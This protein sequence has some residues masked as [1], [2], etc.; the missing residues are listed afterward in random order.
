MWSDQPKSAR[1]PHCYDVLTHDLM[2]LSIHL[3]YFN[4]YRNAFWVVQVPLTESLVCFV[5][6][7]GDPP[8]HPWSGMT[9]SMQEEHQRTA[10]GKPGCCGCAPRRWG[11]FCWGSG[12]TP[13]C[14]MSTP[15]YSSSVHWGRQALAEVLKEAASNRRPPETDLPA[16][17]C[18]QQRKVIS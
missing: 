7:S 2:H 3:S 16:P 9:K 17:P 13:A 8:G 12:C 1:L 10:P 4:N 5:I 14:E 11:H 15:G 6:K 18:G